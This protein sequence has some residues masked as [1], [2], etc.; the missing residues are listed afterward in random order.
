MLL[1]QSIAAFP[2][3]VSDGATLI[4][5]SGDAVSRSHVASRNRGVCQC[6]HTEPDAMSCWPRFEAN[7]RQGSSYGSS[8]IPTTWEPPAIPS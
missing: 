8:G 2:I 6:F 4:P 5:R 7:S 3:G 1:A